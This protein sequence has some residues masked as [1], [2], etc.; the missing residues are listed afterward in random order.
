[1]TFA[2]RTDKNQKDIVLALRKMGATVI[3]LSKVGKGIPDLL[4]GYN[5]KTALVEIKSSKNAKLTPHQEA[6]FREWDG[7]TLARIDDVDGAIRL[8]NILNT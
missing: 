2:K 8:I 7:G 4:V 6:F 5:K 3:D 1:M